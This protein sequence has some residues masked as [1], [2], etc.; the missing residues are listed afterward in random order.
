MIRFMP[1]ATNWSAEYCYI[2]PAYTY[3]F[4]FYFIVTIKFIIDTV[5][6]SCL[7]GLLTQLLT[8][9]FEDDDLDNRLWQNNFLI[10][11]S[12]H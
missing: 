1:L 5:D 2:L 12:S 6:F 11:S 7:F 4:H 3:I 9:Y 8:S 10:G